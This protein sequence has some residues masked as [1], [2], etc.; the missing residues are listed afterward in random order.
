VPPPPA[1]YRVQFHAGFGFES[2]AEIVPR[3]ATL[4]IGRLYSSPSMQAVAGSTHGYDVADPTRL[5]PELGGAA[6]HAR[7][8]G[9]LRDAGMGQVLDIVPNHLATDET[10]RWWWDV[11]ENGPSSRYAAFFDIEWDAGGDLGAYRVLVPVLGDQ[12]GRILEAHEVHL[13]R[14]GG[15]FVVRCHDHRLPLSP[16]SADD[17]VA[18]AARQAG[19]AEL[20]A[21]AD[22]L[23]ALPDA[24]RTDQAAVDERHQRKDH[25]QARL[26]SLC[27]EDAGV[28]EALDAE[29]AG[30]SGDVDRLDALLQRQNYRLAYWRTANEDVD[31]RRFFNIETLAGVRVEDPTV[32]DATHALILELVREGV[33]DE[34][35]VDHVDGLRDPAGYLDRLAECTDRAPVVVEKI[36]AEGEDLPDSWPVAGTTGY[37]FLARANQLLVDPEVEGS[38]TELYAAFTGDPTSYPEIVAAA[39]QQVM[40]DELAAEVERVTRLAAALC[41]RARRHRDHTHRDLR[42]AVHALVGAYDVYRTYARPG[43]STTATDRRVVARAV[44]RATRDHPEVDAELL[45]FLG[46][47]A[48]GDVAGEPEAELTWRLQQLTAPVMAKGVEDTAFYRYHRLISLNEVGGD[49]GRFGSTADEF[50]R[51]MAHQAESWPESMLALSTH[52][53]KRSADVRARIAALTDVAEPWRVAVE[54]WADHNDPHRRHGYPDRNTEYLLYQTLVGAWPIGTDR[55]AAFMEKAT[56]EAKVHTSWTDP[57]PAYDDA[58]GAF[59]KAVLADNSFVAD[60]ETFLADTRLVERGRRR[61]LAQV[62]LLL[63]CPGAPDIY[64]GDE[65]WDLSLVDPDNRRTVDH[66]RIAATL[67]DVR[68]ADAAAVMA[69]CDDGQ[70]KLWLIHRLLHARRHGTR[71]SYEPIEV[72][73]PD[74]SSV[75]AHLT[76]GLLAVVPCRTLQDPAATAVHLPTG[77]WRDVLG[78]GTFTDTTPVGELTERFPTAVLV[79]EGS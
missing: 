78:G 25:L 33:V 2:A 54:R 52:D 55:L 11:L 40:T 14:E 77:T 5:N 20:A 62:T 32:F 1:S 19:S 39:K 48:A 18:A 16:R 27:H 65:V 79:R 31:Y 10:N 68:D 75:V 44:D 43:E 17:L 73:G 58:V 30:L 71:G 23:A 24:R 70:P 21:I 53:T 67:D 26:S 37:E 72:T 9:A 63:T 41:E 61:S 64:Q 51:A 22:D 3:L 7:L 69:R 49:P 66:D 6:G 60:L 34:L 57:A 8:V 28:A 59:V 45:S 42:N 74:S 13:E 4:G 76:A 50:H 15:A 12:V 56:R 38:F 35:R 47:I 36:L 29:L 46:S